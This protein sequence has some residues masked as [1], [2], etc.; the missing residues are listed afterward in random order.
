MRVSI[1]AT[2][3]DGE[4]PESKSINNNVHRIYT[5]NTGYTENLSSNVSMPTLPELGSI[6][7]ATALKLDEE[8]KE[9]QKPQDQDELI[10]GVSLENAAYFENNLNQDS[11][12]SSNPIH[13]VQEEVVIDDISLYEEKSQENSNKETALTNSIQDESSPQLFSDEGY[14]DTSSE[15]SND[16]NFK[17]EENDFEIP[18]FLRK[19]KS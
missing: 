19:Q 8:I 10:S 3:L 14:L 4:A 18:A 15:D 5:R 1:V 7:G 17:E 9:D 6:Q 16:E 11:D 12:N 13:Q 2:A